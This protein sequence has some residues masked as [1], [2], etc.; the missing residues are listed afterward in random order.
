MSRRTALAVVTAIATLL[1]IAPAVALTP[2][3][4]PEAPPTVI[5]KGTGG[6]HGVGMSQYGAYGLSRAGN[7]A[8]QIIKHYYSGAAVEAKGGNPSNIRVGL[9][10]DLTSVKFS[11]KEV[12]GSV[13]WLQCPPPVGHPDEGLK[14]CTSFDGP[15][16]AGT[17]DK[18]WFAD[19][20][21][22]LALHHDQVAVVTAP[23]PYS[24]TPKR[25]FYGYLVFRLEDGKID[26]VSVQPDLEVYLRGLAEV[27]SSWGTESSGGMAALRAQ[28]V[29]GR[30]YALKKIQEGVKA[31]CDCHL[32]ATPAHQHW[33]GYDKETSAW[34]NLWV[35]AVK[36]TA[37]YVATYGGSL[38]H[39]YY[40]ASHGG[41]S[42]NVEDSWAYG[43]A[44][45]PYLRSVSDKAAQHPDLKNPYAQTWVRY[46]SNA[47]FAG[48]LGSDWKN[49]AR[50]QIVDRTDGGTPR[51]LRV[52]AF[53]KNGNRK[54]FY[55]G[56][57]TK[58]IAGASLR[59]SSVWSGS[60]VGGYSG[61][62]MP[63]SQISH[64]GMAPFIDDDGSSHEYEIA[65][66]AAAGLTVGCNASEGGDRYCPD[67]RLTRAEMATFI[68]RAFEELKPIEGEKRFS[69]TPVG[70][71]HTAAITALADAGLTNGCGNGKYCPD[72]KLSRA[73]MAT[74]IMR[75]IDG[76]DPV[77]GQTRF[78]D[79]KVGATHTDAITAI[80]DA[81][82]TNG[83]GDGTRY[84]P[85]E[86]VT[87][88]Q[89]A[90]FLVRALTWEP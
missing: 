27:P 1:P 6:G 31:G 60:T 44:S 67:R 14:S 23:H 69:D 39:T 36:G 64:I 73:E 11:V 16:D 84:C 66:I 62:K 87:R 74:F 63:S 79:V 43:T 35:D 55:W 28:A 72:R 26:L 59:T 70:A 75:V 53:D 12:K 54:A 52:E 18:S 24:S 19:G 4:V 8:T 13:G 2:I 57:P 61:D 10:T 34:G 3:D 78:T 7:T 38:I 71:T 21:T 32:L 9:G 65:R 68:V 20:V 82:L 76:I 30:T 25:Y 22:K 89:M 49:V 83:C 90:S 37:P 47:K 15:K 51:T 42:E 29:T 46:T 17:V 41:R 33:V 45:L 56:G 81:G 80:K 5:V 40:S 50:I 86:A 85:E 88:G 77:P 48:L 58:N